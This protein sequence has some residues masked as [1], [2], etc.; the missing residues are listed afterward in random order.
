[1][2]QVAHVA[3]YLD[4]LAQGAQ[5]VL[6]QGAAGGNDVFMHQ[7]EMV[8]LGLDLW[9]SIADHIKHVAT[10]GQLTFKT[11]HRQCVAQRLALQ[12][13]RIALQGAGQG[14]VAVTQVEVVAAEY[15]Q[16][17]LRVA[18]QQAAQHAAQVGLAG[19]AGAGDAVHQHCSLEHAAEGDQ[20][21]LDR[22][23]QRALHGSAVSITPPPRQ[24]SPS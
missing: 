15:F 9:Q 17:V 10:L 24:I 4:A 16:G 14:A 2:L 7:A 6:I 8:G 1:M 11:K 20:L 3:V 22:A 18:H 13:A 5:S 23:H 19:L 21:L 12:A